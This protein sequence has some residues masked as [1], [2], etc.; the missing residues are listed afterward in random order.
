MILLVRHGQTTSNA[1]RLLVGRS[2]PA[3]TKLGERQA[4][5]LRPL[6]ANVR[7]VWSSPLQRAIA[8]ATLAIPGNDPVIRESFIELDYGTFDGQDLGAMSTEEWQRITSDHAAP[9]GGGES[10]LTLDQ[11]VHGELERLLGDRASLMHSN[12][13]HLVIITHMSPVK[14]ATAWALGVPG[15]AAWRMQLHN[16]SI[17]TIGARGATPILVNFNVFE[18]LD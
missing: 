9:F 14:S 17:T 3:L 11:R 7:E 10:L 2:D 1:A 6:L 12:N 5:A 4:V 18:A 13:E 15:T 8:T 16:G